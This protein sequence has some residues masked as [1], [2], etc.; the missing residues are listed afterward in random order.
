MKP[1]EIPLID[2][3]S[4]SFGGLM[5]S[6]LDHQISTKWPLLDG[7]LNGRARTTHF[8]LKK[9]QHG[10]CK[11]VGKTII[12]NNGPPIFLNNICFF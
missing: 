5:T 1:H 10:N 11:N 7:H 2:V 8:L 6:P 3:K 9:R 12:G 4:L